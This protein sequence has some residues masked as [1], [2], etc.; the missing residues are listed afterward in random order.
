MD[1][2]IKELVDGLSPAQRATLAEELRAQTAPERASIE[3]ITPERLRD[4]AHAA[5]VRADIAAALQGE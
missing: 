2:K 5:Q 4:P 1:T 3:E